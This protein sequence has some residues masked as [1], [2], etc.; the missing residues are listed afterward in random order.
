VAAGTPQP[1]NIVVVTFLDSTHYF[2]GEYGDSTLS[3]DPNGMDG[4]EHG[5]YTWDANTG[6]FSANV[7][8]DDNGEWGFSH[9]QDP[10]TIVVQGNTL[11]LTDSSGTAVLYRVTE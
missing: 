4:M 9:P 3:G 2:M 11:T 5:T 6:A 1:D 8:R 7:T 10:T